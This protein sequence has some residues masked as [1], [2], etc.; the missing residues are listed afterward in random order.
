M[1][2]EFEIFSNLLWTPILFIL[3]LIISLKLGSFFNVSYKLSLILYLWHTLFCIAY[4]WFALNFDADSNNYF[5]NAMNFDNR[6]FNFG[7]SFIIYLTY[8]LYDF[9]GISYIGQ[10]LIHNFL[11]YVGLLAFAAA[12][13][14]ATLNK[15]KYIRMFGWLIIFLPTASFWSTGLGKD[16]ISFMA[17][18]LALWASLD[19]KNRK[20]LL[21]FSIFS[22][23]MVRPH[24]GAALAIAFI[25][26]LLFDKKISVYSKIFFGTLSISATAFIIP[27]MIS[28]IG[29]SEANN[30]SDVDQYVDKRQNSNLSGG[31]SLDISSMSLP[32]QMITYLFRPLP[33]EAH[34]FLALIASLD[35]VILL[36]LAIM[37][38]T[39]YL[40]KYK[41]S[42]F[43]NRMFLWIYFLITLLILS[44]TT[45][46]LGIAMRQKWMFLPCLIFLLLSVIGSKP[47]KAI[48]A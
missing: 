42:I 18:G 8:Y 24:M 29:L 5:Y 21:F 41:A 4:I 6:D 45:A 38:F 12:V 28:Y 48:K 9:L 1:Y 33:F 27:L 39:A 25:L 31:S 19:F 22:M 16:A 15:T 23:F 47:V 10:F 46:N 32:M 2:Y 13:K 11:G 43:S 35:N 20:F 40:K 37:G 30:L 36:G 44:T 26:S 14:Q 34:S 7:T 3:F 17:V